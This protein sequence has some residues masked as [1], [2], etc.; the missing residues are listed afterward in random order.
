MSS[1]LHLNLSSFRKSNLPNLKD[2]Y[3]TALLMKLNK[4]IVAIFVANGPRASEN[5]KS[6][7]NISVLTSLQEIVNF[8]RFLYVGVVLL[9]L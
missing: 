7:G 3:F 6:P 8:A 9:Q 4:I 1:F 2:L 5:A